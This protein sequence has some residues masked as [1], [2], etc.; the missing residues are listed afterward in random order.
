MGTYCC[1][2]SKDIKNEKELGFRSGS[3]CSLRSALVSE[4]QGPN[5]LL[6]HQRR[7]WVGNPSSE[8]GLSA[9]GSIPSGFRGA[10]GQGESGLQ[11]RSTQNRRR[12]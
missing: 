4:R 10:P 5:S 12:T 8:P 9:D 6:G 1:F 2:Y 11:D 3:G 7:F